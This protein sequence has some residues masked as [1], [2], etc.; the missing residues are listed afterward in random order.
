MTESTYESLQHWAFRKQLMLAV[1]FTDIVGSTPLRKEIGDETMDGMVQQHFVTAREFINKHDGFE[2]KT[3]GDEVMAVF[4]TAVDALNYVLDLYDDT[5]DYRIKI[6]ATIHVGTVTIVEND[7]RGTM[8]HLAARLS[9]LPRG[10]TI[11]VS[12]DAQ[13]Q[14]RQVKSQR[15]RELH[16]LR[17]KVQVKD[18]QEV[19]S[20][21]L[22]LTPKMRAENRRRALASAREPASSITI[23]S[24]PSITLHKRVTLPPPPRAESPKSPPTTQPDWWKVLVG[25]PDSPSA[26]NNILA[27]LLGGD[28]EKGN[29]S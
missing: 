5:G 29:K 3:I 20:V 11:Y 27:A 6:R 26:G 22:I 10:A 14:I 2:I 24:R 18:F 4:P 8:V 17:K 7:I 28:P 9:K 1:V 12:E 21:W 25:K 13:V 16:S 23:P 19:T 15:H